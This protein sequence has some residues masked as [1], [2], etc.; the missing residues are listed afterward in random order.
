[1]LGKEALIFFSS[2]NADLHTTSIE[3][4][5]VISL[6]IKT[7]TKTHTMNALFLEFILQKFITSQI[8]SEVFSANLV[9]SGNIYC[10]LTH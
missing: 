4:N 8:K 5:W 3:D 10:V 2:E 7:H 6:K 1:M 9:P